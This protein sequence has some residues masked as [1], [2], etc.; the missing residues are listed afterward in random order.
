MSDS[1]PILLLPG[2]GLDERLFATQQAEFP[3][4]R[5]PAWIKPRRFETLPAY[6][7]R[8]ADA[9][10]P[11]GPCYVGGLSFGGM[12]ALEVSRHLD[13]RGVFLISSIRSRDE[14]PS[15]AR[16]LAPWAWILPPGTDRLAAAAGTVALWT[17]GPV[18]PSRWKRF[19]AHLSKVRSPWMP[20]AC[21]AVVR[22]NPV[23]PFP[24]PVHQIHGEL[25]PVLPASLTTPDQIVS[26]GGHL[27]PLSHPFAVN[28]FLRERLERC[29][30]PE[31]A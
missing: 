27:L 30:G 19:G 28:A 1:L 9:V 22:W 3:D 26:R 15:W 7:R 20:W 29:D 5:V 10:N 2:L 16:F 8:M 6:A 25:D 13:C 12:V 21:R 31:R 18:L 4:I 23:V 11:G 24:S 14:L 17:V